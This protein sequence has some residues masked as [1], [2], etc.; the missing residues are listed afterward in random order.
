MVSR[1]RLL[2]GEGCVLV[3]EGQAVEADTPVARGEPHEAP[4][5]LD[6]AAGLGCSPSRVAGYLRVR[7]GDRLAE[8]DI[9]AERRRWAFWRQ[10]V[11][12]PIAGRVRS[13]RDGRLMLRVAHLP[14]EI[15]AGMPGVV[16]CVHERRGATVAVTAAHLRGVWGSAHEGTGSIVVIEGADGWLEASQ[17]GLRLRGAIVVAPRVRDAQAIRRAA[18][19]LVS[20]LVVGALPAHLAI[21][22][23]ELGLALLAT[24]GF[25]DAAISDVI[26]QGLRPFQQKGG[27][28]FGADA[29]LGLPAELVI[30]LAQSPQRAMVRYREASVGTVVQLTAGPHRGAV[31]VISEVPEGR[32]RTALG[33]WVSGV[34]VRLGRGGRVFVA[35]TN[36]Q[37]LTR[38]P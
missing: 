8:G 35:M 9:V 1:P 30:P 3:R 24:E 19:C 21:L 2:R 26:Y 10:Q 4:R 12:S 23:E 7:V 6:V 11:V 22:C 37:V 36:L 5:V 27:V 38:E 33:D 14:E 20:G 32:V 18:A 29:A 25:G 16:Q 15:V 34:Y 17:V 13:V 31:G 28:L